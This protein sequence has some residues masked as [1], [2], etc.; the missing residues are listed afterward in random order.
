MENFEKATRLKLRFS[1][2]QGQLSTEDLFDLDLKALD[3]IAKRV[4]TE[5]RNEGEESF[6]PTKTS[7]VC[8]NN[9]LRLEI[10][11]FV[12]ADKVQEQDAR[13]ARAEKTA[14]LARLRELASVKQ[15]EQ[16]ASKSL[17]EIN[18]QILELEAA[19]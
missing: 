8:T 15:N 17:E 12:I 16:F 11:K 3:M 6:I 2:S 5:L 7:K 13:K 10:L 18:K 4:N 9:T 1:T 19:I 14:T